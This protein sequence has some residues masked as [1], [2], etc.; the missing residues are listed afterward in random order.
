MNEQPVEYTRFGFRIRTRA[1]SVVENLVISGRD[2]A[3]ATRKLR[4]MYRDCQ[5][6][7]CVTLRDDSK[8]TTVS[9]EDIAN[10]ISR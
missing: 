2:E 3:D 9:F 8:L 1:G 4:Q 6:L 10:L 7:E 5:V